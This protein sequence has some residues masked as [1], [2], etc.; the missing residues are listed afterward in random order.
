MSAEEV[1]RRH[2]SSGVVTTGTQRQQRPTA[3][4]GDFW[5]KQW[6]GTY[7][8]LPDDA[9]DA[10]WDWDLAY[11][12]NEANS[13]SAGVCSLRG[14]GKVDEF[15]IYIDNIDWDWLE[16]PELIA[17]IRERDGPHYIE[18]KASGKSARQSLQRE[19][20]AAQEVQV[21]ADKLTRATAVQPV[22]SNGRVLV[23]S[24]L[25]RRLL[26]GGKQ[27]LLNITA[28]NLQANKGDIDLNDAF[29]QAITRHVG[30]KPGKRRRFAFTPS[31]VAQAAA[32]GGGK[33]NGKS[34][35]RK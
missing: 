29:V 13:A 6:F 17:F 20:V 19:G 2:R 8:A 15:S 35:G 5:R 27:G 32:N 21:A 24:T 16:F 30:V 18:A 23:R 31:A 11:G 25:L 1:R 33:G 14:P 7:D 34:N 22:V 28:E 9:Y 10:G 12:R 3:P 26:E 4:T